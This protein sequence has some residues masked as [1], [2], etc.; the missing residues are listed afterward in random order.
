VGVQGLQRPAPHIKKN[1]GHW[2][3]EGHIKGEK[4][5]HCTSCGKEMKKHR[6]DRFIRGR[7]VQLLGMQ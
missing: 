7:A 4:P 1:L 3:H 5:G 2:C 6:S